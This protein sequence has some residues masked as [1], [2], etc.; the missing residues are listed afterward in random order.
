MG[1]EQYQNE[2]LWLE[3]YFGYCDRIEIS[4]QAQAELKELG[5]SLAELLEM[6]R[7]P[8]IEWADRIECGCVFEVIGRNSDEEE[9]L[10]MGG[11]LSEAQIVSVN[12]ILRV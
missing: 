9:F 3:E 2:R 1:Q 5:L 8:Q 4:I 10:V 12:S 6:F 7:L 11:F